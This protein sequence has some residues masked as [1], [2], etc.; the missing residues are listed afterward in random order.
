MIMNFSFFY[1]MEYYLEMAL[2][3]S[4]KLDQLDRY[5]SILRNA[6]ELTRILI[7]APISKSVNCN[8]K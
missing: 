1:T 7:M 2:S 4:T 6:F 5:E 8:A 3:L